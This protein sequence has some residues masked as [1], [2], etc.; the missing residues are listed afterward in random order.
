M[1]FMAAP[2]SI[3]HIVGGWYIITGCAPLL[4]DDWGGEEE[5]GERDE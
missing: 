4:S 5:G 2:L 1:R 3:D